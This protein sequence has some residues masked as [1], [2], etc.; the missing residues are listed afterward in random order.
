MI[1]PIR[2]GGRAGGP[3]RSPSY[4]PKSHGQPYV[5]MPHSLL[6]AAAASRAHGAHGT[7]AASAAGGA[8]AG[9][10]R[11]APS[12][13]QASTNMQG[14]ASSA[15]TGHTSA[16]AFRQSI[17]ACSTSSTGSAAP[18]TYTVN[19][20][21]GNSRS[22]SKS[23]MAPAYCGSARAGTSSGS[24]V[25]PYMASSPSRSPSASRRLKDGAG[26]EAPKQSQPPPRR[27]QQRQPSEA[28]REPKASPGPR[29]AARSRTPSAVL[30]PRAGMARSRPWMSPRVG[31]MSAGTV[32]RDIHRRG[33]NSHTLQSSTLPPRSQAQ[34]YAARVASARVASPHRS[35]QNPRVAAPSPHRVGGAPGLS[36]TQLVWPGPVANR[37]PSEDRASNHSAG[38]SSAPPHMS[39]PCRP[40][41]TQQC[42]VQT[43]P[44]RE[45]SLPS[46]IA[47]MVA[48]NAAAGAAIASSRPGC[49]P[50]ALASSPA[51]SLAKA[52]QFVS[53]ALR[54]CSPPRWPLTVADEDDATNAKGEIM[55]PSSV[56]EAVGNPNIRRT[57]S[58]PESLLSGGGALDIT[59]H[60]SNPSLMVSTNSSSNPEDRFGPCSPARDQLGASSG[61][62][63]ANDM[64]EPYMGSEQHENI[65]SLAGACFGP[66][67]RT[68][69]LITREVRPPNSMPVPSFASTRHA[70]AENE[71][72]PMHDWSSRRGHLADM[73]LNPQWP[74]QQANKVAD[75]VAL[76]EQRSVQ[77]AGI[78]KCAAHGRERL[79]SSA[80]TVRPHNTGARSYSPATRR[81]AENLPRILSR[82]R[83]QNRPMEEKLVSLLREHCGDDDLSALHRS[84][85]DSDLGD[86]D[87]DDGHPVWMRELINNHYVWYKQVQ[88]TLLALGA[89]LKQPKRCHTCGTSLTCPRCAAFFEGS[90]SAHRHQGEIEASTRRRLHIDEQ[91]QEPT[92]QRSEGGPSLAKLKLAGLDSLGGA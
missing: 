10:R 7:A 45:E 66:G 53:D 26:R 21:T 89:M 58:A 32:L 47:S 82:M 4:G 19:S 16:S 2:S 27:A 56:F 87:E 37:S 69:E 8:G 24:H 17:G 76:M 29:G 1:L 20:M 28:I 23:S 38:S 91:E 75:M 13:G 41:M 79:S 50:E 72:P 11:P 83:E 44:Q 6:G 5:T 34:E 33:P 77:Q 80:S 78:E 85:E 62:V 67:R 40:R 18:R 48:A 70:D 42:A 60:M 51:A 64:A 92:H 54:A 39:S 88:Q 15:S 49:P 52:N 63:T 71:P 3:S 31:G 30:E 90:G 84:S 65:G 14:T 36:S 22:P 43:S 35:T 55:S 61:T 9:H 73:S 12:G 25:P 81:A 68:P 59:D 74:S 57:P 86:G 46:S